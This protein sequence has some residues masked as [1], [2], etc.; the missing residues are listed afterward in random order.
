MIKVTNIFNKYELGNCDRQKWIDLIGE[1][2]IFYYQKFY[3]YPIYGKHW[4]IYP[5]NKEGHHEVKILKQEI[6][7]GASRSIRILSLNRKTKMVHCTY[8]LWSCK[9][10]KEGPV[11]FPETSVY[12]LITQYNNGEVE[13][14]ILEV[15]RIIIPVL[16]KMLGMDR[17]TFVG[18]RLG[19][20]KK[21]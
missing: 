21:R 20:R 13:K 3:D 1:G 8:C 15:V 12:D 10:C 6:L 4:L 5:P 18:R 2:E 9:D 19:L 17:I 7:P 14:I 11:Q 16:E